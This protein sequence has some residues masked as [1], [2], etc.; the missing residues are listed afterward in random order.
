MDR[1]SCDIV[2]FAALCQAKMAAL[3]SLAELDLAA[4]GEEW[5]DFS[6]FTAAKQQHEQQ[7]HQQ[8]GVEP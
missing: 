1:S 8:W 4:D 5:Q 3:D 7:H 2:L 6:D